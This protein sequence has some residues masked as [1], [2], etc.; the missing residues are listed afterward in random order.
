MIWD[1]YKSFSEWEFR[2]AYTGKNRMRPEFIDILQQIRNTYGKPMVISSGYRDFTHP[3][4]RAKEDPGEHTYG[5]AADILVWN[6]DAMELFDIAFHYG[7]RR[8]GLNQIGSLNSRFIHI[9]MGDTL[10]LGFK[11]ALWTY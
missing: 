7:I 10:N 9:G 8:L 3:L 6:Q 11:S 1:D 4:E 2:C 5:C